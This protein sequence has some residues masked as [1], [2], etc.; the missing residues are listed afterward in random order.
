MNN[1]VNHEELYHV[2]LYDCKQ[3][4]ANVIIVY[5]FVNIVNI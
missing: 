2:D 4:N 1:L 5:M 3:L